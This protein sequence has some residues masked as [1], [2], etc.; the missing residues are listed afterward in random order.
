MLCFDWAVFM[1]CIPQSAKEKCWIH[2]S[3]SGAEKKLS[4][5]LQGGVVD[6]SVELH[7]RSSFNAAQIQS[8]TMGNSLYQC[9][10]CKHAMKVA[11]SCRWKRSNAICLGMVGGSLITLN[12]EKINERWLEAGLKLSTAIRHNC[13]WD[14][15]L[16]DPTS[17]KRTGTR[18]SRHISHGNNFGL[19]GVAI[20]T[21]IISWILF[22]FRAKW[23]VL[24]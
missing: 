21:I 23:I 18:F 17:Q 6:I 8:I 9:G 15:E 3:R 14:T 1:L 22:V 24:N 4:R 10:P 13:V 11:F 2:W 20:N 16:W 7:P 5:K 12:P 19:M